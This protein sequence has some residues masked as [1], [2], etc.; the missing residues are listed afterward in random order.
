MHRAALIMPLAAAALVGCDLTAKTPVD[1]DDPLVIDTNAQWPEGSDT[2]LTEDELAPVEGVEASLNPQIPSLI[3]VSWNQLEGS[4]VWVEFSFD[5]DEWHSTPVEVVAAGE[6][7]HL[8]LGAPFAWTVNYRIANDL[9][10]DGADILYSETYT[11]STG[12]LPIG[13]PEPNVLINDPTGQD[14]TDR[15][16]YSSINEDDGG[17]T[18]GTYWQFIMDRKGRVVWA[19]DTP[20]K[21]WTI[22]V[23]VAEDGEHLLFDE[24]TY[25]V[26][27]V[28]ADS[29]V[30][31]MKIDGTIVESFD[32]PY[33]HHAFTEFPDGTIVW[34]AAVDVSE[35][36]E[37]LNPDGTQETIWDCTEFHADN[38]IN[39]YCQSNALFWDE[40]TDTFLYS[41]Y[42]TSL[43]AHI[44][45]ETGDTLAWW[46]DISDW[47]FDPTDSAFD[48]QHG[49]TFTDEGNLL[50]S[51]HTSTKTTECATR[52]YSVDAKTETLV[53]QWSY[54][55]GE[56][57]YCS[58]AGEA[59]RLSNG[60]TLHN[61]GSGART[62]EITPDGDL[63]WDV[64]WRDGQTSGRL[65]GRSVFI[66]DLYAFA[67]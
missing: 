52:E 30:H 36:L 62:R 47:E 67:P 15:Y 38:G 54:G 2:T 51:T 45:H 7:E 49:A 39:D 59:H 27:Y 46:G 29:K 9:D 32:T 50:L 24:A 17:W 11:T 58:T 48:W 60:N 61:L 4:T 53:E 34:G 23:R 63:V 19:L 18:G 55:I 37:K 5:A 6:Q 3:Y 26:D 43:V 65:Q 66:E 44:D 21:H 1:S 64:S 25:W 57:L 28:G 16:L 12:A 42:T 35:T 13:L 10:G 31:K 33:L 14:P 20:D 56:G 40:A 8:L 22:Y 41:F